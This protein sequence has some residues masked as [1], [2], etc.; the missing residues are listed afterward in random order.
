MEWFEV[1]SKIAD[2]VKRSRL[3]V[4]A[5]LTKDE[6][7]TASVAQSRIIGPGALIEYAPA[8]LIARMARA[9]A[10]QLISNNG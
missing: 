3:L 8:R 10:E 6:A 4:A 9:R 2:S 7:G 5:G 1:E